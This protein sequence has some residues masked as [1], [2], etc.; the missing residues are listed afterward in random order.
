MKIRPPAAL[1]VGPISRPHSLQSNSSIY[2]KRILSFARARGLPRQVKGAGLRTLSRRGSWVQI[3]PPAPHWFILT[4][5]EENF[6]NHVGDLNLKGDALLPHRS[7]STRLFDL[8]NKLSSLVVSLPVC[9]DEASTIS[10]QP[11]P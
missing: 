4:I 2:Q 8:E 9:L 6:E 7:G 10:Q 3:P 1:K 5:P 11:V